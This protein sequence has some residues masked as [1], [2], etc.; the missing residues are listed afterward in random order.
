MNDQVL[1]VAALKV[2]KD[3]VSSAYDEAREDAK[4]ALSKGDRLTARSLLNDEK[5]ASVWLTDPE[6]VASVVDPAA[7]LSWVEMHY[8]EQVHRPYRVVASE[9]QI[10]TLLFEHKPEWLVREEKVQ[11]SFVAELLKLAV[12]IGTAVGPE[13]EMD[14]PG[15]AI[16]VRD[17]VV[18]CRPE[19]EQALS[20]VLELHKAGV[21]DLDGTVRREIEGD[22]A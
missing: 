16:K 2:L 20:L 1:R 22:A 3:Y 12:K 11:Q 9:Q 17:G 5:I 13:G 4:K 8:P 15:I 6:R 7:L 14:V 19:K 10:E 18:T 21:L